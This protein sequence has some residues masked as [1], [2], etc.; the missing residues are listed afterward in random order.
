MSSLHAQDLDKHRWENRVLIIKSNNGLEFDHY[1]YQL[2]VLDNDT[3]GMLERK[4]VVYLV[5]GDEYNFRDFKSSIQDTQ[6]KPVGSRL[7]NLLDAN[8]DFQLVLMGLDGGVKLDR[9]TSIDQKEL[10]RIIDAMP[11]RASEMRK[12]KG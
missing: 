6:W 8:K 4:L 3:A 7:E 2:H 5:N 1:S 10:F 11:M 9:D 12:K